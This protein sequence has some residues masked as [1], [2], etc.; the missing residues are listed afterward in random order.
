MFRYIKQV[1]RLICDRFDFLYNVNLEKL[2][3]E[4]EYYCRMTDGGFVIK[5]IVPKTKEERIQVY[6]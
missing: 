4:N 5:D 1:Y 6:R 3:K 2:Q